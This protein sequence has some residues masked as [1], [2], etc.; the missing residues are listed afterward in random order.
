MRALPPWIIHSIVPRVLV[1]T[2]MPNETSDT[3]SGNMMLF[4]TLYVNLAYTISLLL[5]T[6]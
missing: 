1:P 6:S 2:L 5:Y 4:A 3:F